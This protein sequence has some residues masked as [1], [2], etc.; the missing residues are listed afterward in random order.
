[1]GFRFRKSFGLLPGVRLNASK[2]GFSLSLGRPGLTAN[3]GR[4][5]LTGSAGLPG[6]GLSYSTRLGSMPTAGSQQTG[7]GGGVAAVIIGL[8][9]LVGLAAAI[10]PKPDASSVSSLGLAGSGTIGDTASPERLYVRPTRANCRKMASF[11]SAIIAKF[12]Q[13]D[14]LTIAET[15]NGWA[16]IDRLPAATCWVSRPLLAE[17]EISPPPRRSPATARPHAGYQYRAAVRPSRSTY[18]SSYNC[19]C[20]S[21]RICVGPRGGRYCLTSGGN[22][23]YG[24]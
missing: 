10:A 14:L 17:N 20:G 19:P 8:L 21:G 24:V 11:R 2:S 16:R 12:D 6:T 23:R 18:T 13:N 3:I 1:M 9:C 15:R 22:K 4:K 7:C 5:G